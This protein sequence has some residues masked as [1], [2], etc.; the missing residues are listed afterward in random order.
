MYPF[1]NSGWGLA[2][3][4]RADGTG[5]ARA[6][7]YFGDEETLATLGLRLI[8]GRNFNATDVVDWNGVGDYPPVSGVILSR[9]L[10][11][12]LGHGT[13]M[14]GRRVTFNSGR[15]S[16]TVVGVVDRLQT[17]WAA[18]TPSEKDALGD[19]FGAV[20]PYRF[21]STQ[22]I[23]YVLRAR[24][25]QLDAAMKAAQ[26]TLL[27]VSRQRAIDKVQSLVDA[28]HDAERDNRAAVIILTIVSACL[29]AVSAFGI[30]GLGSFWVTQRRRQIGIRRALGATRIAIVWHF[31][32]ENLL[33]TLVG[34]GVGVA[35]A[36][37]ANLW[38]VSSF[39]MQRLPLG[40]LATGAILMLALGQLA[41]LWP[42]LRAAA[43]PP[44]VATRNV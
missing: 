29:L 27:A 28:K 2:F 24:R 41:V 1:E 5:A 33:I 25:G 30:V 42:A 6:A 19:E 37:A 11:E 35:V 34:A 44:A 10:A 18:Q 3:S 43:V 39:S 9:A 38:M 31:Q 14:V 40:Y 4:T 7:S 15:R 20:L 32:V 8:A 12:R 21:T 22:G 26:D 23:Y 36:V 17:G 16:T 13:A